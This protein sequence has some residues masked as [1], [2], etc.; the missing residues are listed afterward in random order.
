MFRHS[1]QAKNLI[2]S[3]VKILHF[4]RDDKQDENRV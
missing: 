4:V 3:L 1:E 2:L